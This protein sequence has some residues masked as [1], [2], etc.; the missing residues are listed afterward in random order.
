MLQNAE[1]ALLLDHVVALIFVGVTTRS[2]R[3]AVERAIAHRL[4]DG[5][6]IFDFGPR[7]VEQRY[8]R[9]EVAIEVDALSDHAQARS[10]HSPVRA[11]DDFLLQ[12]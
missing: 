2:R 7:P 11:Q 3:S 9:N 6:N 1:R 8:P 10:N 5:G 12:G 4:T